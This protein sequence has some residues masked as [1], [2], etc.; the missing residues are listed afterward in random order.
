MA[1]REFSYTYNIVKQRNLFV[2]VDT[3]SLNAIIQ[4]LHANY[5]GGGGATLVFY[6]LSCLL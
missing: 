4:W 6:F 1:S 3:F 2:S 5:E